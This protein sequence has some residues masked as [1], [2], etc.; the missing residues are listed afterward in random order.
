[1]ATHSQ[2]IHQGSI[3]GLAQVARNRQAIHILL[4]FLQEVR[5]TVVADIIRK[6]LGASWR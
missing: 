5:G 4:L 2:L 1:M 3:I 6:S